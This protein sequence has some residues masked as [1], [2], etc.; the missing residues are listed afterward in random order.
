MVV[1]S[2][3]GKETIDDASFCHGCG[4]YFTPGTSVVTKSKPGTSAVATPR[5]DRTV[6][7]VVLIVTVI[8]IAS[9]VLE[10]V[11]YDLTS[12]SQGS[13]PTVEL[14]PS[15]A[16]SSGIR[17]NVTSASPV[18]GLSFSS[19][20][21]GLQA[22]AGHIGLNSSVNSSPV[23]LPAASDGTNTLSFYDVDGSGTL[24]AGDFMMIEAVSGLLADGIYVLIVTHSPTGETISNLSVNLP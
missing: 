4:E 17:I 9:L 10:Y 8:L 7:I 20:L 19:V 16:T 14:S 18:E 13:A 24:T 3:C 2:K 1:C 15:N 21:I 22:P 6:L 5:K 23:E 12:G 11:L